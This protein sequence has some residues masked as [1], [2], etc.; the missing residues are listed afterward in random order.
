MCLLVFDPQITFKTSF[1]RPLDQ[2]GI[3]QPP[4]EDQ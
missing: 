4:I 1:I 3:N 2:S